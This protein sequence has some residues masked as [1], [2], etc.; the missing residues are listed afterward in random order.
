MVISGGKVLEITLIRHGETD[1]NKQRLVQGGQTDAPLNANGRQ[2]AQKVAQAFDPDN[3]G[4]IIVSPMI[5]A[6]ETAK[7]LTHTQNLKIDERLRELDFGDWE[8]QA[9]T[10]LQKQYSGCFDKQTGLILPDYA[11]IAHGE[12][13]EAARARAL[14]LVTETFAAWPEG[15]VLFVCHGTIIRCLLA[16]L[17]HIAQVQQLGQIGNLGMSQVTIRDL[18]TGDI[19]LDF[20]NRLF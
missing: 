7:I 1:F 18:V 10:E 9:T 13:F 3:Y 14:A 6:V 19:R 20:Y 12:T 5:R 4:Q 11:S 15:R 2:Q 17:M 16:E 8:G